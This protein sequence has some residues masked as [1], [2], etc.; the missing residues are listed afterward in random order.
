MSERPSAGRGIAGAFRNREARE[1]SGARREAAEDAGVASQG[2]QRR[3]RNSRP[4]TGKRSNPSYTQVSAL[5]MRDVKA[6]FAVAQAQASLEE[7]RDLE[8]GE[9]VNMLMA[10]FAAGG[11]DVK[12]LRASLGEVLGG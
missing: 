8:F 9:L 11:V 2:G 3:R 10:H 5:V 1:R 7:G 4:K 6:R 12:E